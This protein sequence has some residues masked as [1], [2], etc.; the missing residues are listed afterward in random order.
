MKFV[1]LILCFFFSTC[2]ALEQEDL[3]G[4]SANL[5]DNHEEPN[6]IN[7]DVSYHIDEQPGADLS[8]AM[9]F[10]FEESVT[11]NF[12]FQNN[13]DDNITV[14]GISGSVISNPDGYEVAN[15]TAQ[16]IG[17][18]VVP[19]NETIQFQTRIQL[20]L[21]E[22]SFFLAPLLFTVKDEELVK[23]GIR[24]LAIYVSPPPMSFFN[25]SF[26]S[27]QVIFGLVVVAIS[28]VLLNLKKQSVK[29]TKKSTSPRKVDESWLPDSYKK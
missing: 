21:P 28:Y 16:D 25:P 18:F 22:G 7:L 17:P 14:V 3:D 9:E 19:I 13:E 2:F 1:E 6:F 20:N 29:R 11:F 4:I 15:I 27:V 24:P 26:I 10:A 8:E 5:G 23:V 12:K